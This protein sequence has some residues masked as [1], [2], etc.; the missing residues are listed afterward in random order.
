ME[1]DIPLSQRRKDLVQRRSSLNTHPSC[2][3]ELSSGNLSPN[4]KSNSTNLDL[5]VEVLHNVLLKASCR[6]GAIPDLIFLPAQG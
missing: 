2:D 4:S 6:N 3:A 5:P 1:E